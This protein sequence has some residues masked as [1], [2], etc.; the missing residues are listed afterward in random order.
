MQGYKQPPFVRREADEGGSLVTIT[1]ESPMLAEGT[2]DGV[3]APVQR[4][5][6]S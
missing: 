3:D 1:K 2:L 5:N 6:R 4:K